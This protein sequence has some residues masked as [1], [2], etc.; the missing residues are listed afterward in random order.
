MYGLSPL[1]ILSVESSVNAIVSK[2]G[3]V[4]EGLRGLAAAGSLQG[5]KRPFDKR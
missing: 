5:R 1:C 2:Q 4:P 3:T